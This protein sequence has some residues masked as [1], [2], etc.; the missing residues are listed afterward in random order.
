MSHFRDLCRLNEAIEEKRARAAGILQ[1]EAVRLIEYYENWLG[2]PSYSWVDNNGDSHP[3]VE[4]GFINNGLDNFTVLSVRQIAATMDGNLRMGVRTYIESEETGLHVG[5]ILN[6]RLLSVGDNG[7][8]IDVIVDND[9]PIRVFI[10]RSDEDTWGEVVESMKRHIQNKLK[11]R[12]PP[13]Y[14]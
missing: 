2:L 6:L 5:V 10:N 4:T 8:N 7:I 9:T 12:Y 11:K 13:A 14:L 1:N 3:Y